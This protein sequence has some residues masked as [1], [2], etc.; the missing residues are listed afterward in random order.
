VRSSLGLILLL[1]TTL[2]LASAHAQTAD[3]I[4]SLRTQAVRAFAEGK[5]AEAAKQQQ[6]L[7]R[8]LEPLDRTAG[9]PGKATAQAL[10]V[11][12]YYALFARRFPEALA[13]SRR[14][15]SLDDDEVWIDSNRAHAL[16]YLGREKEARQLYLAH[17][18]KR[19]P[20]GLLWQDDIED[21]FVKLTNAGIGHAAMPRMMQALGI[22][23]PRGAFERALPSRFAQV[24]RPCQPVNATQR[25]LSV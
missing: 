23:Q 12:A 17:R 3:D 10:G 1:A 21:D 4:A 16:M 13:A 14:G 19:M 6:N 8:L 7:V 22:K 20:S 9:K 25:Q 5:Y 18:N 15:R 2:V 24:W 11:F